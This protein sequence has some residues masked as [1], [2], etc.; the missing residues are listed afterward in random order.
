[1]VDDVAEDVEVLPVAVERGELD[2]ADHAEAESRARLERLVDAVHRVMVGERQQLHARV[3]A[4]RH[5]AP[6]VARRP[7]TSSATAGRTSARPSPST[8][9]ARRC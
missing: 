4:G 1:V 5:H 3:G 8:L 2:G 6:A 7:S 9:A